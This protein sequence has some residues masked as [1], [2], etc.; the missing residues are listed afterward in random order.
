[1]EQNRRMILL[2]DLT[3]H[4]KF[5]SGNKL[6]KEVFAM[7]QD[8]VS[9]TSGIAIFRISLSGIEATDASFPRESVISLIKFFSGE[10]GFFLTEL[11]NEDL[12]DNWDYAAKAKEQNVIVYDSSERGYTVIGPDLSPVTEGT[13]EYVIKAGVARTSNL[14]REFDISPQTA[15]QRLKKLYDLGLVLMSKE[16]A[17]TGGPEFVFR[18]IK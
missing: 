6:G 1:M 14:V 7:L 16:T 4:R 3:D 8:H 12:R 13:L 2:A 17:A 5:L 18:A 10:H 11:E 15:S 9:S